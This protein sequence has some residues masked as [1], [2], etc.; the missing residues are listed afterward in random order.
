[1]QSISEQIAALEKELSE[2][3]NGYL[4]RK[5]IN[6]RERFYL[7]WTEDGKLKSKYM[8]AD[9]LEQ[10][11]ASVERR[12]LLQKKLKDLKQLPPKE[13]RIK[14]SDERRCE[15]CKALRELSCQG[16]GR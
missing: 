7:Q 2:C 16:I 15:I 1:M 8:K 12:K 3:P 13:Y 11:R 6:G 5:M 14:I 10:V 9:E 4:S